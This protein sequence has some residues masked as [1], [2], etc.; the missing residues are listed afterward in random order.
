MYLGDNYTQNCHLEKQIIDFMGVN[1]ILQLHWCIAI[2]ENSQTHN[3][4]FTSPFDT[5]EYGYPLI[6]CSLELYFVVVYSLYNKIHIW[7]YVCFG[8]HT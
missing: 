7:Y 8:P 4:R 5:F 2:K 1:C 6:W 3:Q